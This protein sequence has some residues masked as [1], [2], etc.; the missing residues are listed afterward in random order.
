MLARSAVPAPPV[1]LILPYITGVAVA[2]NTLLANVGRW[3]TSAGA[4]TYA[5]QWRANSV[6][7]PEATEASL[8][9]INGVDEGKVISVR[10]IATNSSGSAPATSLALAA[11]T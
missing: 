9:T 5:Y 10:V 4:I 7:I 8:T 11:L 3:A 2:G 6:D 1:P